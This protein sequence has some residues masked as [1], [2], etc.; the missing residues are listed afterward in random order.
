MDSNFLL[1]NENGKSPFIITAEHSGNQWPA[2]LPPP[3]FPKDWQDLHIAYDRGT[4]E[5]AAALGAALDAPVLLGRYTRLLVDLN[6][7]V[8][9]PD[10]IAE[11]SDGLDL[12]EN[13]NLTTQQKQQRIDRYYNDYQDAL[14]EML[15]KKGPE[16]M[17]LSLHSFT[18]Q[19]KT[20]AHPRP[21]HVGI[22]FLGSN[23]LSNELISGLQGYSDI[24]VGV[25]EPYDLRAVAGG[26][27]R[28]HAEKRSI[29][30]AELEFR[31]D[32]LDPGMN[33]IARWS[34]GLSDILSKFQPAGEKGVKK[35][36]FGLNEGIGMRL[37]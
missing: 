35:T 26:T 36:L 37:G 5:L 20:S 11:K 32:C 28:F 21:W 29:L 16:A 9:D 19:L 6:R 31:N 18:P 1:I 25:N 17:M 30:N 14:S 22:L 8:T 23:K 12:P 7:E 10:L 3:R 2:E 24:T 15:D 13:Q 33:H 4:K 34:E 27:V